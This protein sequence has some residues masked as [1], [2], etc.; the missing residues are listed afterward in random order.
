MTPARINGLIFDLGNVVLDYTFDRTFAAWGRIFGRDPLELKVRFRYDRQFE[1]LERGDISPEEY[2]AHVGK[3]IEIDFTPDSFDAGWNDIYV[4]LK[5][6]VVDLIDSYRQNYWVVA[7]TNTTPL[8]APVWKAKFGSELNRVFER[9]FCSHE[10]RA[11]KPE[12]R[13]FRTVLEYLNLSPQSVILLDD[14]PVF[15][16]G[17]E[18]L[19]IRSLLV[20]SRDEIEV[21]LRDTLLR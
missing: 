5:P 15:V 6:G 8:H 11:R 12:P 10:I 9:V 17:A 13:A 4:G 14:N 19:G 21:G 18:E 16:R 7:L 2:I 20:S 1:A 3:M